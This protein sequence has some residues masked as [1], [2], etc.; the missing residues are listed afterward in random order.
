VPRTDSNSPGAHVDDV[1]V[2]QRGA[3]LCFFK[4]NRQ[5]DRAE[6]LVQD[7]YQRLLKRRT[8]SDVREPVKFLFA[9]A[10]NVLKTATRSRKYGP[11]ALLSIH[12]DEFQED[13]STHPNLQVNDDPSEIDGA[14]L[15]QVLGQFKRE[16][17]DIYIRHYCDGHSYKQISKDTGINIHTVKKY[18]ARVMNHVR[19]HYGADVLSRR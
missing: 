2:E 5:G 12:A 17:V 10:A 19:K 6:D 7:V 13:H 16:Q 8:L 15:Q 11:K 18:L 4:L 9:V 3:L 1:Y 14:H